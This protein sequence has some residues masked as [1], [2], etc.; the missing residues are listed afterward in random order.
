M[1]RGCARLSRAGRRVRLLPL[2]MPPFLAQTHGTDPFF[3]ELYG[4][5]SVTGEGK[6]QGRSTSAAPDKG[7]TSCRAASSPRRS[8]SRWVRP[9]PTG[10]SKPVGRPSCSSATVPRT[11][12][13]FWERHQR[14]IPVQAAGDVRLCGDNGYAGRNTARGAPR[15]RSRCPMP[16]K[17]VR[18]RHLRGRVRRRRERLCA[19]KGSKLPRLI[20]TAVRRFL[21]HQ[22]LPLSRARRH[23]H[24]LELGL[25]RPGDGR[26]R[27]DRPRCAQGAAQAPRLAEHPRRLLKL[28]PHSRPSGTRSTRP[29]RQ[30]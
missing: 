9:S 1:R 5:T 11:P 25:S 2:T 13:Y 22:V 17:P 4:R 6:D 28:R 21:Q 14:R 26:A 18:R 23:R 8:R 7:A 30:A 10:S 16:V 19:G 24:R 29:F 20:A 27:M 3:S 15:C 12:A